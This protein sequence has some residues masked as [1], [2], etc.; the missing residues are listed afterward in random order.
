MNAR[1]HL[2]GFVIFSI[3][4]G[5]AILINHFLT[6][7]KATIPPVVSYIAAPVMAGK[8]QPVSYHVRQVSL[9]YLNKK[10]YTEL[11]LFIEPNQPEPERVW[12]TTTYFSPD[13]ARAEDWTTIT[14]IPQPFARGNGEVFVAAAEWELPPA[15]QTPGAGY[16]ARVYVSSEAEGKFYPPDYLSKS[17][18]ADAVPVVVH[19]PDKKSAATI[20]AKKFSR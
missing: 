16:F 2:A 12:V 14:E 15:L 18:L 9:D 6:I 20:P 8:S 10:S 1:K 7:P 11:S 13:S 19:W 3:I 17:D 4:L 5:S